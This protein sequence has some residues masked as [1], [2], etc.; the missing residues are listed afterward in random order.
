MEQLLSYN[1]ETKLFIWKGNYF[2]REIPKNAGFIFNKIDRQWASA[3]IHCVKE[4]IGYADVKAKSA[5]QAMVD[6][7]TISQGGHRE[8]YENIEIPIKEGMQ[9]LEY[10]KIGIEYA[11]KF[12]R[13]LNADE[14]GC[15]S[16]KTV[17]S[18]HRNG[19]TKKITLE[20]AYRR[21]NGLDRDNYNWNKNSPTYCRSLLGDHFGLNKITSIVKKGKRNVVRIKTSSDKELILTPDHEVLAENN[22]WIAIDRLTI[23]DGIYTSGKLLIMVPRLE[24]IIEKEYIE[25]QGDVYDIVMDDPYRN[26]IANGIVVHNCGKTVQALGVANYTDAKQ[27]LVI[28][29]ASLRLNWQK[30]SAKW[31]IRIHN[32]FVFDGTKNLPPIENYFT[33]LIAN[34][35]I[36]YREPVYSYLMRHNF[37]LIVVDEAHYLKNSSTKRS[38]HIFGSKRDKIQGL[39]ENRKKVIFLTG[40]PI[41]NKPIEIFPIVNYI[42]PEKFTDKFSFARKYCNA[43]HNRFGWDFNGASN[44]EELQIEL[45]SGGMI[46]R[47]KKDVLKEL[48]PKVRQIIPLPVDTK[49]EKNSIELEIVLYEKIQET[50]GLIKNKMFWYKII[51]LKEEYS[52]QAK[53][54]RVVQMENFTEMAKARYNIAMMK[55]PKVVE[56]VKEMLD[57][58]IKT[59]LF[60]HH[61]DVI[62]QYMQGLAKYHPVK[63]DGSTN[64]IKRNENVQKFQTDEKCRVFIGNIQAAGTGITLTAS[65]YVVFGEEDWVPANL[66]QC[67]DRAHRIGQENNVIVQ[68]LIYDGS[69]DSRM[70]KKTIEKQEM[71]NQALDSLSGVEL[72]FFD[73]DEEKY[74]AMMNEALLEEKNAKNTIIE[75]DEKYITEYPQYTNLAQKTAKKAI[76]YMCSLDT[77]ISTEYNKSGWSRVDSWIGHELNKIG[78]FNDKYTWVAIS[79][80]RK[81]RN[82]QIDNEMNKILFG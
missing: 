46:R 54:L 35:D 59:I 56:Y 12:D 58:D 1:N 66:T 20:N 5:Y 80:L 16:G 9:Y 14:M 73:F 40:T 10:Q 82:T 30:E 69:L 22:Q 8:N 47:L 81:Y 33:F 26:F 76:E 45:R 6:N 3:N 36:C 49:Q 77:D 61:R 60:A 64:M 48:P 27:V 23:G 50:I 28:C 63:I 31:L 21:F 43:K 4:I 65:S 41:L 44:L 25:E 34:Y 2:T 67:E 74:S 24:S 75:I 37:D 19:S 17:L 13:S 79:I 51:D 55:A 71:T 68:H 52:E 29:P 7:I 38:K 32:Y 15:L 53:N 42:N 62:E 57:N 11:L 70:I 39:L 18:I 78:D 72:N